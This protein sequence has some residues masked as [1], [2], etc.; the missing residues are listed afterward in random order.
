M[1]KFIIGLI[2]G[3][4]AGGAGSFLLFV[5]VPRAATSPGTPIEAPDGNMAAGT[6]QIALKQDFFNDA[7][8]AVFR[9]MN[10]PAFPLAAELDR[11][12]SEIHPVYAQSSQCD[13]S[14]HIL[15]EGSGV[16]TGVKFENGRISAPLAFSGGYNSLLGCFQFTGWAQADLEL[17]FDAEQQAVFG[18]INVQTVNLDGVN[19]LVSGIVTPLVQSSINSRV[20][21]IPILRGNN[22]SFDL[23]IAS[24]GGKLQ[25]RAKD[26]RAEV[27]DDVLNL[28]VVYEF[29]G[30]KAGV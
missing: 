2:I 8:G 26:V 17:R 13:G 14:I 29:S 25:V 22:I 15:P 5:G 23:P 30:N 12:D 11:G 10:G 9:D 20:N 4:I 21:P 24:A 19:P 7:L 28:F 3:L 16:K 1:A 6:A 27:K 18:R